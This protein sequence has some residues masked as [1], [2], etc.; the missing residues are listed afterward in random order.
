MRYTISA[1][2]IVGV[3][4]AGLCSAPAEEPARPRISP[5]LSDKDD[6]YISRQA[7]VFLKR[8]RDRK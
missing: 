3:L 2:I 7:A 4:A 1:F 6:H 5:L 8:V